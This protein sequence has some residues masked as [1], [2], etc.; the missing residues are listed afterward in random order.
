MTARS[1]DS[2]SSLVTVAYWALLRAFL[3]PRQKSGYRENDSDMG[4]CRET[5]ES[6]HTKAVTIRTKGD[7]SITNWRA[8]ATVTRDFLFKSFTP[9][10]Q[11][12][13][14]QDKRRA[15]EQAHFRACTISKK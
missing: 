13:M 11:K 7:V 9:K 12:K 3:R 5:L 6:D 8:R 10:Q 15:P 1:N 2:L 14:L 4:Q